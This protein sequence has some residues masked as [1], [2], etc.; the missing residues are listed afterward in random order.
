M[1]C[2]GSTPLSLGFFRH[3]IV[4]NMDW[5]SAPHR[6]NGG[7]SPSHWPNES[8][9]RADNVCAHQALSA[10]GRCRSFDASGDGYGRSEGFAVAVLCPAGSSAPRA[11]L[12]LLRGSAVNQACPP[13]SLPASSG[14]PYSP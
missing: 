3:G 8:F 12:G 4:T 6:L 11:P 2:D 7:T 1:L 13:A 10:V 9:G 14:T 5:C